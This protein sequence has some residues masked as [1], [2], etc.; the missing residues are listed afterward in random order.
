MF[1]CMYA[2]SSPTH[3]GRLR[4]DVQTPLLSMELSPK[5]PDTD[6]HTWHKKGTPKG[7]TCMMH[8]QI[9]TLILGPLQEESFQS[10]NLHMPHTPGI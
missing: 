4:K 10:R 2:E 3:N 8:L 5:S 1:V 7:K 6:P 9:D